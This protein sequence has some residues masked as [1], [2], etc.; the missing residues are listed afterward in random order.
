[1]KKAI[2]NAII[3]EIEAIEQ[4]SS[5]ANLLKMESENMLKI[6]DDEKRHLDYFKKLKE[7]I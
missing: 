4:Y 1:M 3:D 7:M 5:L 2:D 6:I